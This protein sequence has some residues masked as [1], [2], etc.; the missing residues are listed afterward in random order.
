MACSPHYC[1]N[2]NTGTTTCGGHRST[3]ST[4]RQ[5]NNDFP[6]GDPIDNALVNSLK[7]TIRA[8]VDRWNQHRFYNKPKYYSADFSEND[9]ISNNHADYILRMVQQF[10]GGAWDI[11]GSGDNINDADWDYI[12]SRYDIWRQQCICNSD[13]SCN[14]VCSCHGN[15]G[16]NYS[17]KR[18]K[19]DIKYCGTEKS[20]RNNR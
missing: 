18:L 8:E 17:D 16:C 5:W 4:N 11:R 20:K 14:A 13:C 12:K 1:T 3:C 6:E 7:N 19:K 15:C 10:I 9:T 2:H